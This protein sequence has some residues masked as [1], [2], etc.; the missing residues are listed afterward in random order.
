[1]LSERSTKFILRI[2]GLAMALLC[3]WLYAR[4]DQ[5]WWIFVALILLPDLSMLEYFAGPRIGAIAYN[6]AHSWATA[7]VFF[8]AIWLLGPGNSFLLSLPV[9]LGAHIGFD[10]AL[11]YGLKLPSGFKDTHLGP[12][13]KTA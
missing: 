5:S 11:G 10:R 1:M 9:I 4:S 3:L 8:F 12:I 13:G 6:V 2:E 7:V